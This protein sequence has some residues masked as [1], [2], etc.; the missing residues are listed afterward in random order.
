[1]HPGLVGNWNTPPASL[2]RH[3]VVATVCGSNT[4]Q[5]Q[6]L[7][8]TQNRGAASLDKPSAGCLANPMHT[9]D[10]QT[11]LCMS[12]LLQCQLDSAI[13]QPSREHGDQTTARQRTRKIRPVPGE[14]STGDG[15]QLCTFSRFAC[16]C[17]FLERSSIDN[18]SLLTFVSCQNQGS[19]KR[20]HSYDALICIGGCKTPI[21]GHQEHVAVVAPS[22]KFVMALLNFTRVLN[23]GPARCNIPRYSRAHA[24]RTP[25]RRSSTTRCLDPFASGV[26]VGLCN[27]VPKWITSQHAV[28]R[29]A[30][31][32]IKFVALIGS[33]F[34]KFQGFWLQELRIERVFRVV[35]GP[36]ERAQ[37][38]SSPRSSSFDLR[39][40]MTNLG[41]VYEDVHGSGPIKL[42]ELRTIWKAQS[43]LCKQLSQWFD[44][45]G[46]S[47]FSENRCRPT[48]RFCMTLSNTH[49][50]EKMRSKLPPWH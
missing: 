25:I 50:L 37:L 5:R 36:A 12:R 11:V 22:R 35:L 29:Q 31:F 41:F 48:Y 17:N 39:F 16:R 19:P 14:H 47:K 9:K 42:L 15:I 23:G 20:L 24:A 2:Q 32:A 8:T 38:L 21:K 3:W 18:T 13:R 10:A 30:G 43:M 44:D 28:F 4:W 34:C 45:D 7:P 6:E 26:E 1:M 33:Q 40:A 49:K 46:N 27:T